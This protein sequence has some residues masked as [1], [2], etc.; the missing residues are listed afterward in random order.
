MP[1]RFAYL[2]DLL[3]SLE[4]LRTRDPPFLPARLKDEC[5]KT[6]EQWFRCHRARIDSSTTDCVAL[7]SALFPERRTDRVYR[8]KEPS[9]VRILGRCLSLGS[10][11]ARELNGW[12]ERGGG[13]LGDCVERVQRQAEMPVPRSGDEVSVE[14][15]DGALARIAAKCR[16]SSLVV[17]S[18]L[19]ETDWIASD[20]D[21][22]LTPLLHRMSSRDMKWFTRMLLKNYAPVVLPEGLVLRSFHFLLPDLLKFQSSFDAVVPLLKGPVIGGFPTQLKGQD[23]SFY[24]IGAAKVLVPKVGIKVGRVPYLKAR[25]IKHCV[26]MAGRRRMSLERKYDGE[27]CQVHVDLSRGKDCIQ[28][29]SKSGKD[30]T[31][32]REGIHETIKNSL[33]IGRSDCAFSSKCILEAELVVWDDEEG[34]VAEFHKLR[35]HVSRSGVFLG[36]ALDSQ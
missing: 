12:R 14:Q 1:F 23:Q 29:F 9:L 19:G 2:C 34:K 35:K 32:D 10:T 17:R 16:F 11:R 25:S 20:V 13:D 7:L 28:I 6:I 5:R 31:L 4:A 30:S 8:L 15:V 21:G 36:T 26:Q 24:R 22:V 18:R 33:R 27:Y 3:S